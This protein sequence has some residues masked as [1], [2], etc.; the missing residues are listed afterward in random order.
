MNIPTNHQVIIHQGVPV[1][2]VIPYDE[3]AAAFALK[4]AQKAKEPTVPH[5]VAVRVLKERISPVQAW[6]E[7]FGLTQTEVSAR[8]GV[9][10]F[11]FARMEAPDGKPRMS[12]VKKIADA[13]GISPA[14]LKW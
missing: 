3:Y 14:Q 4:D 9:S 8:V 7:Y 10:Q 12:T 6:R 5:E 11:A 1:A 13:L 2:V